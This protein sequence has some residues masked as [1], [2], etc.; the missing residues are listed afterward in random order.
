MNPLISPAPGLPVSPSPGL[1]PRGRAS[2]ATNPRLAAF[3]R[4]LH[5]RPMPEHP[6]GRYTQERLADDVMTNRAHLSQVL[7]GRR[8]GKHTWRRLVKVLPMEGLLLLQQCPS[9]NKDAAAALSERRDAESFA[10]R[11]APESPAPA[12]DSQP[13]TL[14]SQPA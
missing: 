3:Y 8:R 10:K 13:S 1:A 2:I 11:F 7:S 6:D 12:P 4:W 9:W 5:A 14:S